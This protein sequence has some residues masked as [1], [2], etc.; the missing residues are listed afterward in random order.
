MCAAWMRSFGSCHSPGPAFADSSLIVSLFIV[1][2]IMGTVFTFGGSCNHR[3]WLISIT[4]LR[5]S[6]V[7]RG[8]TKRRGQ[9]QI[10]NV[11]LSWRKGGPDPSRLW[12]MGRISIWIT[13]RKSC[14]V[15]DT[16]GVQTDFLAS[17][18][19]KYINPYYI[20]PTFSKL[21]SLWCCMLIFVSYL[22]HPD[23]VS[24]SYRV[25]IIALRKEVIS[26]WSVFI[27]LPT[28]RNHFF[29]FYCGMD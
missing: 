22:G 23:Y 28:D 29:F 24:Q 18:T 6:C 11:I 3:P 20:L 26:T 1:Q 12:L 27:S 9:R 4:R 16:G 8:C 21:K 2:L 19:S 25:L 17:I 10:D 5:T 15:S 7:P 13:E 14:I